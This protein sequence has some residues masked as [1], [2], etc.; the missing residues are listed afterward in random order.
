MS[1]KP[2]MSDDLA[3]QDRQVH[4]PAGLTNLC[5]PA[6]TMI[7]QE[8]EPGERLYI[9]KSGLVAIKK[10]HEDQGV[11]LGYLGGGGLF[12]EISLIQGNTRMASAW[13]VR[14]TECLAMEEV[15]FRKRMAAADPFIQDV[16]GVLARD[17]RSL[18][19]NLVN[20]KAGD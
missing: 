12:G 3:L 8:N 9:I 2:E 1:Q 20:R 17:L 16:L 4:T 15:D 13:A 11:I 10:H 5:F 6:G 7:C 14:D 19:S 18:A